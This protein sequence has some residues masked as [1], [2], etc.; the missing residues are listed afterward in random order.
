M[1]EHQFNYPSDQEKTVSE[2]L[3][4]GKTA[5]QACE[6]PLLMSK[7]KELMSGKDILIPERKRKTVG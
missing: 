7:L 2:R 6:I 5:E 3:A 1:P 4:E